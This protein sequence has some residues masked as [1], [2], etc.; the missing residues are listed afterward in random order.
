MEVP[1]SK[2]TLKQEQEIHLS[3]EHIPRVQLL[4]DFLIY[5]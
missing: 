5:F 2:I 3:L 4:S 1:T